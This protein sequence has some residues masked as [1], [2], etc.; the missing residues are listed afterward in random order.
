MRASQLAG[1]RF[2]AVERDGVICELPGGAQPALDGRPV[3]FGEV[4]E[5]VAFSLNSCGVSSVRGPGV[6]SYGRGSVG[7]Q[8][9][10]GAWLRTPCRSEL[11]RLLNSLWAV[12]R[13][14]R[15]WSSPGQELPRRA[16]AKG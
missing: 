16:G 5:D 2:E 12:R 1:E 9:S 4:I 3:A 10:F 15:N 14:E 6:A 13:P 11:S 7:A 8:F